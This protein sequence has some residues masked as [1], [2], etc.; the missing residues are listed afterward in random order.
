MLG[1]AYRNWEE[2]EREELRPHERIDMNIDDLLYEFDNEHQVAR[3]GVR[4]EGLFDNDD[5]IESDDI[6]DD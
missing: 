1:K 4:R 2:F 5:D 3:R 6:Y